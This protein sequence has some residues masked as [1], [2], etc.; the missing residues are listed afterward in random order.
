MRHATFFLLSVGA[1]AACDSE[2]SASEG[3]DPVV[4]EDCLVPPMA[5]TPGTGVD[6]NFLTL[7]DGD[8]VTIVHGEQGG[9]HI[10]IA[11]QAKHSLQN[12]SIQTTVT[13]IDQPTPTVIAGAGG[14][15]EQV[16]VALAAYDDSQCSGA[17]WNV[18]AFVDDFVTPDGASA[19]DVICALEGQNVEI[20]TTVS[21]IPLDPGMEYC[22]I[23]S[24][25]IAVVE[26]GAEDR[27]ACN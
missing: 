6:E 19:L 5:L 26:L 2:P 8:P 3:S 10:E 21:E 12:V 13:A 23:K 1:L 14:A 7:A 18:R 9:W 17:F 25:V 27:A 11:G 15:T 16:L 22:S 4:V 20:T 24:S